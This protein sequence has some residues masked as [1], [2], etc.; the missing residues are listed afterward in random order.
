MTL[1][2]FAK[3]SNWTN[4]KEL[5]L[6]NNYNNQGL[7]YLKELREEEQINKFRKPNFPFYYLQKNNMSLLKKFIKILKEKLQRLHDQERTN[8]D[9]QQHI[10]KIIKKLDVGDENNI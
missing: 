2:Y 9:E 1:D 7:E 5:I 3:H 6:N 8:S 10:Q 4:L